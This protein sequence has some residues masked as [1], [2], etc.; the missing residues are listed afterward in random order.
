MLTRSLIVAL[1]VLV[2]GSA[3]VEAGSLRTQDRIEGWYSDLDRWLEAVER[4]HYVWHEKGL[5]DELLTQA[6][7][8]REHIPEL[9]DQRIL[10]ELNRVSVFAGD[11]HTSVS[12][13]ATR[14]ETTA[15][16][17]R[18]YF[19]ADGVFVIDASP[20]FEQRIGSQVLAIG[21]TDANE[22]LPRLRDYVCRD[23]DQGARWSGPTL[24]RLTGTLEAI[25]EGIE[26]ARIPVTLRTPAGEVTVVEF[27]PAREAPSSGT[28]KLVPS[29]LP[30]APPPPMYLQDVARS[31][32]FRKLD[33]RTLYAQINQIVNAPEQTFSTFAEQ[34][35]T[36]L[37]EQKP[38]RL[39]IDLRHNNGGDASLLG[40]MMR[41]LKEYEH[42]RSGAEI[43]VLM[44]RNTFSAAQVFLAQI[45]RDTGAL[46][47]GEPS[48]SRPNFVGET[49]VV[50]LPWSGGSANISNRYHETIPGDTR[51]FIP[52]DLPFEISSKDYFANRDPL[53][54]LVLARPIAGEKR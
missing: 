38:A 24:L 10:L 28:P 14:F 52:P 20:G 17:L 34:L 32:W 44:G 37:T 11:G 13:F 21:G 15:L 30:D 18:F 7:W 19:F 6:Q 33:E 26:P 39:V 9:S 5:P 29:R 51:E 4:D 48:S 40:P 1:S 27:Q 23:N 46:F 8:L 43:V 49:N 36:A 31:H 41:A 53:L 2:V 35:G 47:A 3:R 22:L 12:P 54:E 42:S 25:A 16:P 45:D 50:R